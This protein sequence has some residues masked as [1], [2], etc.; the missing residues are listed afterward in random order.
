MVGDPFYEAI[1]DRLSGALDPNLFE[2]CAVDLLR[3]E[4]PTLVPIRGGDDAGMD[5]AIADGLQR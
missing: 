5:G 1:V 4:F 3:K 2:A